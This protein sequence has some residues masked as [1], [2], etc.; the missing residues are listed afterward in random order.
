[1]RGR[2]PPLSGE[3][4]PAAAECREGLRLGALAPHRPVHGHRLRLLPAEPWP[5]PRGGG[6]G[7]SRVRVRWLLAVTHRA[8]VGRLRG[9]L[10]AAAVPR[11]GA[12][13]QR[14]AS[15]PSPTSTATARDSG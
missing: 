1:E 10:A 13:D 15:A 7:R 8:A 9:A 11:R 14:L 3:P 5:A 4:A 6:R 2:R 12:W